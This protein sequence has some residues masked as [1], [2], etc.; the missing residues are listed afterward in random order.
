MLTVAT[1][2][3]FCYTRSSIN[4]FGPSPERPFSRLRE[5][6]TV[7][8][9]NLRA[10]VLLSAVV[11]VTVETEILVA[12]LTRIKA[13]RDANKTVR[14]ACVAARDALRER[15]QKFESTRDTFLNLKQELEAARDTFLKLKQVLEATGTQFPAAG[16][17]DQAAVPQHS[18][19]RRFQFFFRPSTPCPLCKCP[20]GVI[21]VGQVD[22]VGFF[23]CGNCD[24][25]FTMPRTT[26]RA[27]VTCPRSRPSRVH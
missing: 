7:R 10:S 3:L 6:C 27:A 15:K 11:V 2:L 23:R 8:A 14:L 9:Q 4:L 21:S 20:V 17:T 25:V 1:D 16:S 13:A 5:K 22:D 24:E 18:D 12:R 19:K 26:A